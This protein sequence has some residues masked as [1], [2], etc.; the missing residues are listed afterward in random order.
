MD[1][2]Y[3]SMGRWISVLYRQ[4]QVY[5]NKELRELN[6]NSSE[7]IYIVTLFSDHDGMSQDELSKKLFIDKGAVARSINSLE[8]KNYVSRRI[9]KLDKRIKRVYLTEKAKEVE[10]ILFKALDKWN[11]IITV[12]IDQSSINTTIKTLQ[13]MSMEALKKGF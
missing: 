5:I 13:K 4:F 8:K 6:I 11:D 3:D 12:N 1:N 9:D 10:D 7:Y 2:C